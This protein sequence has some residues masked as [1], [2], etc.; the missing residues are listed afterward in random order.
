[1]EAHEIT[2]RRTALGLT[3]QQLADAVGVHRITVVR[4]ETG[5]AAPSGLAARLLGE[6]LSRLEERQAKREARRAAY[7]ARAAQQNGTR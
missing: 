3:Q 7:A 2:Q 5:R 6:T 4:W 1:M